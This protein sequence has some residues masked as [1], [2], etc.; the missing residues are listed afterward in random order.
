MKN[1]LTGN[2]QQQQQQSAITFAS[3]HSP[4]AACH[5]S[6]ISH[7]HF[8][9]VNA[10]FLLHQQ[11]QTVTA[12]NCVALSARLFQFDAATVCCLISTSLSPH[13]TA[14]MCSPL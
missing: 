10:K 9:S 12:A 8:S 11:Q 3:T 14:A 6:A 13:P 5:V 7:F 1:S 2:I 4:F